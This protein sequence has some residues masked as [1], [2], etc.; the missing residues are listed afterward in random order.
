MSLQSRR[1]SGPRMVGRPSRRSLPG[2]Q[3]SKKSISS[4]V[5]SVCV[6]G[7]EVC[8]GPGQLALG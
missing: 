2:S 8:A 6:W 3:K 1:S 4:Q 7:G 5:W